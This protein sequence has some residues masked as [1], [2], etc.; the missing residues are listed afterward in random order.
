MQANLTRMSFVASSK[1]TTASRPLSRSRTSSNHAIV[2]IQR[3]SEPLAAIDRTAV[4]HLLRLR[5]DQPIGQSLVIALRM[6]M[7]SKFADRP[8]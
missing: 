8:T 6:V 2:V 5:T 1:S 7:E 4:R 3:S